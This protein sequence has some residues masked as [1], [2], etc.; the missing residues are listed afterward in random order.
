MLVV[1]I[2]EDIVELLANKPIL[3]GDK[4]AILTELS[5]IIEI[6]VLTKY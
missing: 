1:N 6:M 2:L 5:I 4:K 3:G